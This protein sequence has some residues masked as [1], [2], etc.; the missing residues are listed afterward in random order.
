MLKKLLSGIVFFF[1]INGIA[2]TKIDSSY[3]NYFKDT[4]EI[5]YLHINKTNFLKGEEIWFKAYVLEQNS[6]RLHEKTSNLHITLFDEN[7]ILKEHQLM[8]IENG[9][10]SGSIKIDSTFTK[11][12][13]YINAS[14]NWMR[15]FKESQPFAQQIEVVSNKD[16]SKPLD[17]TQTPYDFQLLAEG[18]H[19]VEDVNNIIGILIKNKFG[20]GLKVKSGVI[21]NKK[22]KVIQEFKTNF[23]GLGKIDLYYKKNEVYTA[24]VVLENTIAL[25]QK[26]PIAKKKGVVLRVDNQNP[27]HVAISL[28]TNENTLKNISGKNYSILVHNTSSIYSWDYKFNS[29]ENFVSL[30]LKRS[31]IPKGTNIITVLNEHGTP[32]LERVFLNYHKD[33]FSKVSLT[34]TSVASDSIKFSLA[35]NKDEKL[36]LSASFLPIYTKANKP[37][38]NIVSSLLVQPYINGEI[39]NP[40]YYFKDT[41]R[42]KLLELDLLLLTQGWSKYKWDD[43]FN[44][45]SLLKNEFENG[46]TLKGRLVGQTVKDSTNIFLISDTSQTIRSTPVIE[47]AF[48][49]HNLNLLKDAR[50]NLTIARSKLKKPKVDLQYI[51]DLDKPILT[52]S[53][54]QIT[55][56]IRTDSFDDFVLTS[57]ELLDT[58]VLKYN[59]VIKHR[60]KS[61]GIFTPIN[62]DNIKT[63]N[64]EILEYLKSRGFMVIEN[65][66][67]IR[68]FN[69]RA[70]RLMNGVAYANVYL[71][72]MQISSEYAE[73]ANNLDIIK[74]TYIRDYDEIHISKFGNGT[75]H[76]YSKR[77]VASGWGKNRFY[78]ETTS[79]GYALKKEYYQPKYTS[80]IDNI[81]SDY[82]AIFWQP[83]ITVNNTDSNS[84]TIPRM[85]QN[86]VRVVIEGVSGSGKL[87]LEEKTVF[88]N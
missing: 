29:E 15:N 1:F 73:F 38:N 16:N 78:K 54:P 64:L 40:D 76:L 58:V 35:N 46:I 19:L 27:A 57:E 11:Q 32:I 25:T 31:K 30:V 50:L 71:D 2:Q 74:F 49:F 67:D 88:F 56:S 80:Y 37:S 28:T 18:G 33:L 39:Q 77:D 60:P 5:P 82:G 20:E 7:G 13:Y 85:K 42:K 21:K 6:K 84:I 70:Q 81:F 22:G 52:S 59:P 55:K 79:Y 4:R 75:I 9:V 14:T 53:S 24:E 87:V 45:E 48:E 23:F 65:N 51:Y 66:F 63:K 17:I 41:S 3:T 36:F 43:I 34:T 10:G 47:N 86:G 62:T 69:R 26:I 72:D 44:N 61:S 12:Y 8:K 68:I 83:N